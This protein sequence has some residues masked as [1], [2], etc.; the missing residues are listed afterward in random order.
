MEGGPYLS[1]QGK[2]TN[3]CEEGHNHGRDF[4]NSE[5]L[6]THL[7]HHDPQGRCGQLVPALWSVPTACL[8]RWVFHLEFIERGLM[9][10]LS[11]NTR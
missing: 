2:A 10:E 6:P 8:V 5:L 7:G 1:N 3:G 9:F 4:T 11:A